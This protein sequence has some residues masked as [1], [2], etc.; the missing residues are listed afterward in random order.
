MTD[1]DEHLAAIR[2]KLNPEPPPYPDLRGRVRELE[3]QLATSEHRCRAREFENSSLYRRIERLEREL[4]DA[5]SEG[6]RH[7]AG[8][9]SC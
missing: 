8:I 3:D 7:R 4:H 5:K 6:G 2:A 1:H 9:G